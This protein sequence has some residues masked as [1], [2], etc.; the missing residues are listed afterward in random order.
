MKRSSSAAAAALASL[1]LTAALPGSHG[2]LANTAEAELELAG[3]YLAGTFD[4]YEQAYWQEVSQT[5]EA[6][7]HRR[8]TSLYLRVDLPEFGEHVYYAHKYWDGDPA[9][10]SFRNLYVLFADHEARATRL[11]LLTIPR[12]ER[13][14][15][16]L[17]NMDLLKTLTPDEMIRMDPECNTM[18]RLLGNQFHIDMAGDCVLTSVHPEGIPVHI[19]V[20]TQIDDYHFNYLS[21]GV[22][23]EGNHAYGPPDL[24]PSR[25][26]RARWFSCDVERPGL[27]AE[28]VLLHDQG[29]MALLPGAGS[30][31][32]TGIRLR[33]FM[34]PTAVRSQALVLLVLPEGRS[35]QVDAAWRLTTPHAAAAPEA[36][37]I[38]YVDAGIRAHC[39]LSTQPGL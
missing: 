1:A 31:P 8:S 9:V 16:V 2:A 21:Y 18:W 7:R 37:R 5:P 27:P 14:D 6:L 33:Q 35:E 23:G 36:T 24:M 28:R 22:D 13:L 4:N 26:L 32:A 29:D 12:G 20:N 11:D 17:D 19:T 38:G 10:R 30:T 34:P 3:K 15:G 39:S 25:E